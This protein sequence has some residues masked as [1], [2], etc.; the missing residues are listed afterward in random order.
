[1]IVVVS[2]L[3][4]SK[5]AGD[6]AFACWTVGLSVVDIRVFAGEILD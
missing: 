2:L 3:S 1:M 6:L 4:F 5:F